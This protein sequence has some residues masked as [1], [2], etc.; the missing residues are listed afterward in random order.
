MDC[1]PPR[2]IYVTFADVQE[3]MM[4]IDFE[5]EEDMLQGVLDEDLAFGFG[6]SA[7][8]FFMGALSRLG[9]GGSDLAAQFTEAFVRELVKSQLVIYHETIPDDDDDDDEEDEPSP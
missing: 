4:N 5:P 6:V 7:V 3:G 9:D 2:R 8:D 1:R